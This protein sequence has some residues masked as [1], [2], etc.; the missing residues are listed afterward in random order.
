M[1]R[2]L[3]LLGL[4]AFVPVLLDAQAPAADMVIKSIRQYWELPVARK[5]EPLE[6][7]LS[8]TVTY[9][10]PGWRMMFV[11]DDAG[12]AAYVPYGDNAYPFK[13]GER[14]LARGRFMPP[15]QDI[16]FE[17]VTITPRT[18]P[19]LA[20][21]DITREVQLHTKHVSKYVSAE[22][23]VD[24]VRRVD[25]GHLQMAMSIAGQGIGCW[26]LMDPTISTPDLIDRRVRVVGVYNPKVG[27]DGHLD[28]LEFMISSID[29][30]TVLGQVDD[31]PGFKL[32]A[33]PVGN[34]LGRPT[35]QLVRVVGSVVTRETGR[36]VR[37]RDGSGQIDVMTGQLRPLA[38][39]DMIEAVGYPVAFGPSWRLEK[40][41]FRA[42]AKPAAPVPVTPGT[43][44]GLAADVLGMS[45]QEASAGRPVRLTGVVTWSHASSPFFFITDSSGGICIMRGNSDSMVR[46]PGRNLEVEGITAMGAFAPV[47]VAQRFARVSEAV[48][49]MARQVS[50]E[51]ALTGVEE[52][53]WVEMRGY[54][55]RIH[56]EGGWNR[57]ELATATSDF[58]AI[59]PATE[60]VSAMIGSVIQL[61]GVCAAEADD[62][63][64]LT[65]IRLWVPGI[66]Y[67][68]VEEPAPD[69]PFTVPLRPLASLGQ[70][71]TVHSFNRRVRVAGVVQH[72]TPGSNLW[73]EEDGHDLLVAARDTTTFQPGDRV[74][75]VGFLGRQA[76]R[77]AL[78]EA[79]V[80]R[81]GGGGQ[82]RPQ[83]VEPHAPP[84]AALDGKL[85]AITGQLLDSVR[86]SGSI[87][88]TLQAGAVIFRAA[89][90]SADSEVTGLDRGTLVRL[91]GVH[92]IEYDQNGR[93]AAFTLRLRSP[94]D[95]VV[96]DKPSW[97]TRSRIL[98][99]TGML[100]FG[101]F[102]FL[103]WNTVLRRQVHRQ[104]DQI[105]EQLERET[106]LQGE[107]ARAGKLESLGLLAGGIA[108]DFN[109]LLTVL[110]GNI[111]L[112]RGDSG[113]TAESAESLE[114]A[115]K[116]A[117]RARDLTQQLL[118]FAK[119]GAP[120]RAAVSLPEIVREVAEFAIRGSK[121]R[122]EFDLPGSLWPANV[123]K[124]Q[125]GQV[126]QN[127]VINA[128]QAMPGGGVVDITLSNREVGN[129]LG[130]VLAP[131]RY[132]RL[133]LADHGPGIPAGDLGRIFDPYFTTKKHGSGLGLATVH[134]I[135]KKHAGH[136]TAASRM[137]HGT[138]FSIWLPAAES[139]VPFN[140]E[141]VTA[142]L[143]AVP[144]GQARV[145]VMDDEVF[146]RNLASSILRRYGHRA[147]AVEDGAAAVQE[148]ARARAAGEP[149]DLV[150]LDLTIPGGMG[151][152]EAMEELQRIDP[153]V[154]AIV[155]SGY[156]NDLVLA[157]YQLHGFRGMISKPYDVADFAHAVENVLK[158][159]RA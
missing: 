134:S 121:V 78:R 83:I 95:V 126:V 114:Q 59:L 41:L 111:S 146:I 69:D 31:E 158:G 68:Q 116:A 40:A 37:I 92:E 107:L 106:R 80:R 3:C 42:Y 49:P 10:D 60:N 11:Q 125:I 17:H 124:G 50:V 45:A 151:G 109:N 128:I 9:F 89:L 43:S 15:S 38:V 47:V 71:E 63:R 101:A 35:D 54:L 58:S 110:M 140:P 36:F 14:I 117:G 62:Q 139:A 144:A 93:P 118:T 79:V 5:K 7:E 67:V 88:F 112:I 157:N 98:A 39:N 104:T 52:A 122:C 64:K 120:I 100:A 87:Q 19:A 96:M 55:R 159:E 1:F 119:G 44:L 148:Y 4:T 147:T 91:T 97:W 141:A 8:C 153:A 29:R 28:A 65:G 24:W 30:V 156:S 16:S 18:G 46:S 73:I 32:P 131:G 136:I 108:H 56:R 70:F 21:V 66:N 27:I 2:S 123:D 25:D 75:A 77:I 34:L 86:I 145:L 94:A 51:H 130:G 152:R 113:L 81:T 72:Q 135:V 154:R 23:Y 142:N 57:L 155:S 105:R 102:L 6:V 143:R 61:R 137:G 132:V 74:E 115:E 22:G 82:R 129:E 99:F 13:A 138:T 90:E 53:Q 103:G 84:P 85:V 149:Y 133:D 12:D 20:S 150:I 33:T 76:G 26:I 127:I 48:L